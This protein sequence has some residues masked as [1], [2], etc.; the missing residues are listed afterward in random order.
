MGIK[1]ANNAF[2]T[3]ASGITSSAT[4]ITVA[5]G[6]GAR[7]P[8]LGAGDYFYA[9]LINTSNQLEIV[10]CTAR[11]G[12]VLTVERAQESTTARAYD[13][14]DR[15]EIRITAATFEDATAIYNV[16]S[17]TTG[18]FGLPVGTTAQRP[19]SPP[20]GAS[21]FN[22]T[23][24]SLE[25]FDGTT[26]V[27]TNLIPTVNSVDGT[28]FAG[29]ASTLTLSVSNAT[30]TITVRFSEGGA[31]VADVANVT[32][33]SGSA[34]VSVPSAV[35]NQTAGDTIAVSVINQD[36]TPSSNAINKTVAALPTGGT[37]TTSGGFRIHTFTGS[38][39]FATGG[40]AGNVEYLVVA[41]GGGGGGSAADFWNAGGGGAGGYISSSTTVAAAASLAVTVGAGGNRGTAT[42][43]NSGSGTTQGS[44]GGGSAFGAVASCIGGGG[45]GASSG[46]NNPGTRTNGRSGGSGGGAGANHLSSTPTGGSG[47]SGQGNNGGNGSVTG[48]GLGGGG[49]GAGGAGASEVSNSGGGAGASSSISGS[50]VTYAS[51]GNTGITSPSNAA[52]NTGNGGDSAR[53]PTGTLVNSGNGGSGIV[54]IRYQI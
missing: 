47:T 42:S 23:T 20:A 2:A 54:I 12:D 21:R 22:T 19:V 30:D 4:S 26:W 29:V 8:S 44:D 24:G 14:G 15:I 6:Q 16:P 41:G 17:E 25:F 18:Y 36:G 48:S 49:G 11:S 45:G 37:I 10:K 43:S 31:T 40:F 53:S 35:F 52:A 38:G 39:T 27:S 9:T 28:I 13:V 1:V 32:V 7:F 46:Q 51:G 50:A 33:T 3:L 34:S 5:S